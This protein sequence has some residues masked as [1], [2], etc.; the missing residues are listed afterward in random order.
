MAKDNNF[1]I[2]VKEC[3]FWVDKLHIDGWGVE[4]SM[5]KLGNVESFATI[6]FQSNGMKA[7]ITFY[8]RQNEDQSADQIREHAKHEIMHL[9][10]ARYATM[11]ENRFCRDEELEQAEEE[12][13]QKLLRVIK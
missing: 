7:R 2:F 3:K 5:S 12:L 8:Q 1:R 4:Y 9:L 13:V 10:I 6:T 11:A